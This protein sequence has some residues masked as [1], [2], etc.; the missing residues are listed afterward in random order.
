MNKLKELLKKK[1]INI[2]KDFIREHSTLILKIF[3]VSIVAVIFTFNF[4][5]KDS[6]EALKITDEK[7]ASESGEVTEKEVKEDIIVD[8]SGEVK[9]PMVVQLPSES[10]IDDAIAAAGGLTENAD[11]TNVN[12]A[13]ILQDGQ[14]IL[15]PSKSAG[16]TTGSTDT[17]LPSVEKKVN[18]NTATSEELRTL[19]GVGP[20]T[21]EK[22]IFHREENG[23][24]KK[25]D[26]LKDVSGIG[27]KTFEKLKDNICV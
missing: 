20:A 10:R 22:I 9:N 11:I 5:K 19:D 25:I 21:A 8:I 3:A 6:E 13:E 2:D 1:G 7:S 27:E 24:F 18:I 15:I 4:F 12:R 14:K 16:G 26:D 17:T 23:R